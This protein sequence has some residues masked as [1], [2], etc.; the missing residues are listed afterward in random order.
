M[1]NLT[2]EQRHKNMSHIRSRDTGPELMLRR[3]LWKVGVRYRKN[4]PRLP[5]RPDIV[6]SR[7]RIAIFVDGDFFH[8]RDMEKISR[9]LKS[10]REYWLP[11]IRRNK[12]RDEEV[13]D[14]LTED[15]WL[16]LRFW[17][18]RIRRELDAVVHEILSY[19]PPKKETG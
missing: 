9:D 3:A 15:G 2:K 5:G 10:R 16:V 14:L 13:N 19:V 18:S 12:E 11:K 1:D 8:G 7:G 6:I 17:E 4:D